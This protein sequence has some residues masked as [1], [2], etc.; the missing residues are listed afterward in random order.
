MFNDEMVND[1]VTA[2]R[3]ESESINSIQLL[4]Y[5]I[6]FYLF[7]LNLFV[8]CK[9]FSKIGVHVCF[10]TSR[11]FLPNDT[12]VLKMIGTH[13][14]TVFYGNGNRSHRQNQQ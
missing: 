6:R 10:K 9:E 5:L 11:C 13:T 8:G 3:H 2:D 7:S 14:H 1:S 12:S 4:F